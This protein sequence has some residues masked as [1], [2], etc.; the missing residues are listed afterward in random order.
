MISRCFLHIGSGKTGTSSI[1]ATL[2]KNQRALKRLRYL[3]PISV[4]RH[5]GVVA[6]FE[7]DP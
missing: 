1:Q 4:G 5:C 3:H 2:E 6:W 7:Q